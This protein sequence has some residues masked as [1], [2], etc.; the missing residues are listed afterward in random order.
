MTEARLIQAVGRAR[1]GLRGAND[2]LDIH[3]WTDVPLPE[4][5]PVEPVLWGELEGGLDGLMLATGGSVAG[6]RPA[7]G[8]GLSGAVHGRH[9]E[10]GPQTRPEPG[11]GCG[12][13]ATASGRRSRVASIFQYA[14]RSVAISMGASTNAPAAGKQLA[15]AVS[16][17][18]SNETMAWLEAKLGRLARFYATPWPTDRVSETGL[19]PDND[20]SQCGRCFRHG[21]R[22]GR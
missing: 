14:I 19:Q 17:L 1:A 15:H 22:G 7:R 20:D 3:L 16:L 10:K 8:Q 4:L 2:P 13:R 9:L 11:P 5:G 18:G 12:R 21:R 6:K